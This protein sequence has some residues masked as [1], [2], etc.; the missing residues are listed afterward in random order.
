ME[1]NNDITERKQAEEASRQARVEA[2]E[3]NSAK[4]NFFANVSHEIRTPMNAILGMTYL[5][6]R[7]GPAPEQRRYLNKIS[8]AADSLLAILNDILDFSKME[9]GKMDLETI[10]FSL[11][12]VLSNLHDT[13]IHPAKQK[14][15]AVVFSTAQDVQPDLI[16]DPLRLGQILINLVNNAIKFTEAG[17]VAVAVSAEEVTENRTRL[18]F[19]ISDTGIGMS[20]DQVSKLFQ[21]FNQAD[22]SHTR[23][24]GGTGL[25]LAISKH[26]CNLMGGTLTVESEPG[27]GTTFVFGAEF[28]IASEAL[29]VA[30]GGKHSAAKRRSIL[31]VDSNQNDWHRLSGIL[32]TNGFRAKTVSSGEETLRELSRASNEGNPFDLVLMDWRMPGI[33]GIEAARQIQDRLD[34]PHTPVILLVTAFVREEV[35]GNQSD[36]WMS[37]FLIKPFKESLLIY[38]IADILR[39]EVGMRLNWPEGRLPHETTDGSASLAGRHVLLVEDNELNRDLAGE[40]LDDLGISVTMAFDG[41]EAVDRV[42]AE[43]FDLVLMDIQMPIMDGLTAT[44]LIRSNRRFSKLPIIAMTAHAMSGDRNQS[45]DAGM[46]DHFTKPIN[47][48]TLTRLLLKWMPGKPVQSAEPDVAIK[49]TERDDDYIPEE[50]EPFDIQAALR[51]TNGKPRLVRKMMLSFRNQFAHATTDLRQLIHEGKREEAER[52]AHTLKGVARTLEA[53]ELGDAAFAVENALRSE[54]VSN[55]EPLIENMGRMLTPAIVAAASLE[56][57]VAQPKD[58]RSSLGGW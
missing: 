25:G 8:R 13:V 9:A 54:D 5:A 2:E 39:N 14:G 26:L 19:S 6:L 11:G 35:I 12:E 55:L 22:A 45:L 3:A 24:F 58:A 15:I 53:P 20:A 1:A 31:I 4:S 29:Q 32:D 57:K 27:K 48:N 18:R 36:P 44:R 43:S 23:K 37:G 30:A 34:W 51:R 33:N 49:G 40:L 41:R 7:A 28:P 17:Q 10:P 46:N 52:L 38:T 42:L 56:V 21:S 50:L 16:G 47:P